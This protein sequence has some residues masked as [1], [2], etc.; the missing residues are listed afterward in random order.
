MYA[1]QIPFYNSAK[2]RLPLLHEA[3]ELLQYCFL[4]QNLI[5]RNL[6]L[7]FKRST[8]GFVWV[9]LTPPLTM[10]VIAVVSS[11]V[12]GVRV[13]HY[14]AF[15]LSRLLVCNDYAQGTTSELE[16][17]MPRYGGAQAVRTSLWPHHLR[18]RKGRGRFPQ[19]AHSA[20]S[21][22]VAA[23]RSEGDEPEGN[24]RGNEQR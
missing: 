4:V 21:N 13:E 7:R 12:V 5:S 22:H 18:H 23:A 1:R 8:F 6:K 11:Q 9:M 16:P 17:V 15:L 19:R 24:P 20:G 14:A 10:I 3:R 2:F